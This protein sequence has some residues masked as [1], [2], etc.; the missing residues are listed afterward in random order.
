MIALSVLAQETPAGWKVVKDRKQTCQM[1][2]PPDWTANAIM[3][4]N[5]TAPDKKANVTFGSKPASMSYAD[6]VKAAKGMFKPV[7]M[8]EETAS[9]TWYVAESA[10]GKSG[11]TWYIAVA[12]SPVCEAQ[13]AFEDAAFEAT[14]K[15]IAKSLK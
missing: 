1:S 5:L 10:R 2:V 7:K 8:I 12:T 15:Q 9:R 14:A 13:I 3:P 6:L 11:T 4:S